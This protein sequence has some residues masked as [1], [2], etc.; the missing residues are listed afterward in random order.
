[1]F[2]TKNATARKVGETPLGLRSLWGSGCSSVQAYKERDG[3]VV[4]MAETGSKG[5]CIVRIG[6]NPTIFEVLAERIRV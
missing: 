4:S 6:V 1:M 3:V 2:D 5:D